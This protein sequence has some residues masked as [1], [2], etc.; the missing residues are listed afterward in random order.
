MK[1]I[2]IL[3]MTDTHQPFITQHLNTSVKLIYN[4]YKQRNPNC[5]KIIKLSKEEGL[6]RIHRP[7]SPMVGW[8]RVFDATPSISYP[9]HAY[10]YHLNLHSFVSINTTTQSLSINKLPLTPQK[11]VSMG[12]DGRKYGGR[13]SHLMWGPTLQDHKS[14]ELVQKIID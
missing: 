5:I 9:P 14:N 3:T 11:M 10:Q 2:M 13:G 8:S 1:I 6:N 4:E 12:K 7:W